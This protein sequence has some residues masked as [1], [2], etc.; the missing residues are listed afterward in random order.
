MRSTGALISAFRTVEPA[1]WGLL[2]RQNE[3]RRNRAHLE[4]SRR[5]HLGL[6]YFCALENA[7]SNT[8]PIGCQVR[9]SN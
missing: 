2:I 1:E 9:P 5:G 6:S 8:S 3:M 7:V 4:L